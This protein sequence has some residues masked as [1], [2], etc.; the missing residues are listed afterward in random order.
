MTARSPTLAFS[1]LANLPGKAYGVRQ[2]AILFQLTTTGPLDATLEAELQRQIPPGPSGAPAHDAGA[3]ATALYWAVALQQA[4]GLAVFESGRLLRSQRT[5]AGAEVSTVS[6]PCPPGS[7]MAAVRT[8][9]WLVHGSGSPAGTA[10]DQLEASLKALMQTLQPFALQGKNTVHFLRAAQA[11]GIPWDRITEDYY[12]YGWGARARMLQSS[13]TDSTS[14]L[15]SNLA[16]NKKLGADILRRAGLPA[17]THALARTA[18]EAVRIAAQ[19]G[20]PVVV[21]PAHLDGGVGVAAGLRDEDSVRR[22][23]AEALALSASILI[24]KHFDGQDYRLLIFQGRLIWTILRQPAGVTGNGVDTVQ[25]LVEQANSDPRRATRAGAGLKPLILDEAALELLAEQQHALTSVPAAREFVRLRRAA[26]VAMGGVSIAA[27]AQ[28]H[29][30]NQRLAEMAAQAFGLDLAGIDLLI[31]DI[32]VSWYE[33]GALICE[34][35]GQ[36]QFGVNTQQHVHGE[37]LRALVPQGGRIPTVVVLGHDNAALLAALQQQLGSEHPRVGL[38]S[39]H[40]AW[41]NGVQQGRVTPVFAA[42]QALLFNRQV[43]ALIVE[44]A[45]AAVLQTGL[46]MDEHDVLLL[47][48]GFPAGSGHPQAQVL[49]LLAP[50]ARHPVLVNAADPACL[51]LSRTLPASRRMEV[52]APADPVAR[53]THLAASALQSLMAPSLKKP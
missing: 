2:A 43:D 49:H 23:F 5:A 44:V 18:D 53:A 38:A 19:L 34:V 3:G 50:H 24:E 21:K 14:V 20:Y 12:Q 27:N 41:I 32:A 46:P 22:A 30:D 47:A 7:P 31:P 16:R 39:A 33:S 26:N 37:V 51:A 13:F 25:A 42:A 35:N 11:S 15:G 9:E 1:V 4:A 52:P 45:D 28:V 10:P 6:I 48:S 8:L 40:G 36:P 17:P 29:P